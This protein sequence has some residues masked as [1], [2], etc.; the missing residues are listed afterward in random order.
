MIAGSKNIIAVSLSEDVLKI[1]EVKGAGTSAKISNLSAQSIAG[2]SGAALQE[3]LNGALK[4]MKAKGSQVVYVV[5]PSMAT[6]KNIEIPSTDPEEIK[7]IVNL[8]AGRHTPFSRD[9][10][11]LG[12]VNLGVYNSNYTRVLLVIVKRSVL[13]EHL[14]VLEQSGLHV[15]KVVFSPEGVAA[16]YKKSTGLG[17]TAAGIIDVDQFSTDIMILSGG[18]PITTRNIPIGKS[19]L[20]AD[21]EQAQQKLITELKQTLEAYKS[22]DI[23]EAPGQ[24]FFSENDEQ[25]QGLMSV[26]KSELSW[27]V[28]S[29]PYLDIVKANK[30]VI[31]KLAGDLNVYSFIDVIASAANLRELQVN[32]MPEEISLQKSVESQGQEVFKVAVMGILVMVLFGAALGI[33]VYFKNAFYQKIR[34]E[35]QGVMEEVAELKRKQEITS[36]IGNYLDQRMDSLEVL[37]ELYRNIPKEIYLTSIV[38]EDTGIVNIQGISDAGSVVYSMGTNLEASEFFKSAEVL[39]TT[40]KKDRGKDATAFEIEVKLSSLIE[41]EEPSVEE[42]R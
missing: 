18:K 28:Q 12:F 20:S 11:E 21:G 22:D 1:A 2:Q 31:S 7:S 42:T 3:T 40:A 24:F 32:L 26:V 27:T 33:K 6:T 10:I 8:Q 39:S 13:K 36:I 29:L 35:Y 9:E 25:I 14:L 23:G 34:T 17:S 30:S 38:M 16:L 5:P 19:H 4:G 41:D 15:S 37:D